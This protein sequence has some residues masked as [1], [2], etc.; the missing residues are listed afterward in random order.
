MH[1]V[2]SGNVCTRKSGVAA[3]KM[4]TGEGSQKV[5]LALIGG[6]DGTTHLMQAFSKLM[7]KYCSK[8]MTKI[9]HVYLSLQRPESR[10]RTEVN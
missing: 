9:L 10:K 8:N 6:E 4:A 5:H 2:M 1:L 7:Q 3:V